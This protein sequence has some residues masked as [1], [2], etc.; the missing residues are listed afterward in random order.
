MD[1]F[2]FIPGNRST[3]ALC[4]EFCLLG[5]LTEH[6]GEFGDNRADWVCLFLK[7][8]KIKIKKDSIQE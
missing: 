2:F 5:K 1:L 7:I 3:D 8:N 4:T 6:S